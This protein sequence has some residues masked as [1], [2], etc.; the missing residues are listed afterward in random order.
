MLERSHSAG[1]PF[2]I[3]WVSQNSAS[4]RNRAVSLCLY[5]MSVQIGS[6]LATRIYTN[7]DKPYYSKGNLALISLAALGIVLSWAVKGYYV[8]RNKQKRRVWDR[9]S[10]DEQLQY[11]LTTKDE[12]SRRLDVQFVH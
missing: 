10:A 6:I 3:G 8:W 11:K 9:M 12:G 7:E 5:N 4:V 1:H 2:L